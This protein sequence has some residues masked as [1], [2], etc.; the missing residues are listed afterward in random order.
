MP[1]II[2]VERTAKEPFRL[3]DEPIARGRIV[4][5]TP[6]QLTSL[7]SSGCVAL[8][9][10]ENEAVPVGDL[11]PLQ[12]APGL[13]DTREIEGR[14][15]DA[16]RAAAEELERLQQSTAEARTKAEAEIDAQRLRA[17]DA[18]ERADADID[19]HAKR[20]VAAQAAADA[21]VVEHEK[22]VAEAKAIADAATAKASKP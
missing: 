8:T 12:T 3:N 17:S 5:L 1:R 19:A 9:E 10:E 20:V 2:M 6:A 15:A 4:Q 16:R 7:V 13:I 21:A 22:R 18:Q 14:L 11:P